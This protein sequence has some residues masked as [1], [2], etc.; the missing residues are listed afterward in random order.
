MPYH[1]VLKLASQRYKK[2]DTIFTPIKTLASIA[3]LIVFFL[4]YFPIM[5]ESAG[6]IPIINGILAAMGS[7][8]LIIEMPRYPEISRSTQNYKI[9]TARMQIAEDLGF[10]DKDKTMTEIEKD[11]YRGEEKQGNYIEV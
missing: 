8:Y 6:G 9:L 11:D 1:E 7:T 3:G 5:V 4:K 10:M 2:V